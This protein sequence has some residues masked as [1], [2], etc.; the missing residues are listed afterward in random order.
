MCVYGQHSWGHC[1]SHV[2]R[3]VLFG[4]RS[5]KIRQSL[6]TFF[7]DLSKCVTSAATPLVP[8]K[9]VCLK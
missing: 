6:R 5:V 3:E 1:E 9:L 7:P 8:N 4:H 2:S